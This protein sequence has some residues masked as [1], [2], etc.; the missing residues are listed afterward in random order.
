MSAMLLSIGIVSNVQWVTGSEVVPVLF[1]AIQI[2]ILLLFRKHVYSVVLYN[3]VLDNG[4]L[5]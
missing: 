2:C 3:V 5:L 1:L 4:D